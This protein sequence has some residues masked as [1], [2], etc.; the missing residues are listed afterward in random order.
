[1]YLVIIISRSLFI[2][3]RV[4]LQARDQQITISNVRRKRQEACFHLLVD[5]RAYS[6]WYSG[7]YPPLTVT[8]TRSIA[9][10]PIAVLETYTIDQASVP[11]IIRYL[12]GSI[13]KGLIPGS[14]F[15]KLISETVGIQVSVFQWLSSRKTDNATISFIHSQ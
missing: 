12:K 14:W 2:P 3:A 1:V 9:I 4:Y 15:N 5:I 13:S 7:L 10:V 8:D 11:L 6:F